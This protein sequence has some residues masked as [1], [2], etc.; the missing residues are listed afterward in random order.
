MVRFLGTLLSPTIEVSPGEA[1]AVRASML[2]CWIKSLLP[3]LEVQKFFR[4]FTLNI[5]QL[6]LKKPAPFI[7]DEC[8]T[9]GE[10]ANQIASDVWSQTFA[11][12]FDART[13]I[14]E[15][16][17]LA[18]DFCIETLLRCGAKWGQG[19]KNR[20]HKPCFQ[21]KK[22]CPGQAS[23]GAST[24][25][26]TSWQQNALRSI[27]EIRIRFS[28]ETCP[29]PD[30]HD[31]QRTISRLRRRLDA[32]RCPHVW[33]PWSQPNLCVL[34][35]CEIW[36]LDSIRQTELKLKQLRIRR[37]REKIK[38]SVASN[39]KYVYRHLKNK[40]K[41][42]P[43]NLVQDAAG[44]VVYDPIHA[45]GVINEKWDDVF[46]ANALHE[47]PTKMLQT[48]WPYICNQSS[49][50]EVPDLTGEHL[51]SVVC[52]RN[53]E[54]SPGLDGWRTTEL[55]SLPTFCFQPFADLFRQ[56]EHDDTEMPEI[57]V[58]AKQLILNKNG[59]S[60][61]MQKR[62]ITVLPIMLLAYTGARF[63]QLQA[64]Q[65]VFMP[66]ELHGGIKTRRMA[67]IPIDLQLQLDEARQS[68]TSMLGLKLDK[69]KCFD[70]IVPN[71][72]AALMLSFGV[73]KHIVRFF[74]KMYA[75]LHRHLAYKS[76]FAPKSTHAA[77]GVAQ[78]CSL[79]LVAIN[80]YMAAWIFMVRNLP[81]LFVRVFIDDSYLWSSL[82]N[83]HALEQAFQ[84]T[85]LWD[86]LSGQKMN[87]SKCTAWGNDRTAR[88]AIRE[89]FSD[90]SH[91]TAFDVLGTLIVT[92]DKQHCR[93]SDSKVNKIILDAR[94][95]A[96]LPL[97][98]P[99]KTKLLGGKVLPQAT[100]GALI[101]MIPKQ[102]TDRITSAIA[103]A[104]WTGRPHW[105][106]KFLVV[107]LLSKA[108]RVDLVLAKAYTTVLDFLRVLHLDATMRC[109]CMALFKCAADTKNNMMRHVIDAFNVFG[110]TID[111]QLSI[112]FHGSAKIPLLELHAKD[113]KRLLAAL[114]ANACYF[115]AQTRARKDFQ[116]P[117]GILDLD[118]TRSSL[119]ELKKI[120]IGAIPA[121]SFLDAV[122]TGCL[123]TN[124]RLC[125]ASLVT[126]PQCR[127]CG[128]E[129]ESTPHLVHECHELHRQI[130][131]PCCHEFGS[132]FAMMGIVEHPLGFVKQRLSWSKPSAISIVPLQR[133]GV[134]LPLWTDG[135]V[136]GGNAFWITAGA[137]AIVDIQGNLVKSGP[138]FHW[139]LSAFTTELWA[140]LEAAALADSF[141]H[142]FMDCK[143]VVDR[144]QVLVNLPEV[145]HD[146]SHG[147]W[148]KFLLHL[149]TH[150]FG[151]NHE[152]FQIS[153][154]PA[155]LC[156]SMPVEMISN[157]LA[158]SCKS[159]VL[160]IDCNRRADFAAKTCCERHAPLHTSRY[161]DL[162]Q[163]ILEHHKWLIEV[164][165][166]LGHEDET[167]I[168]NPLHDDDVE[169]NEDDEQHLRNFFHRWPWVQPPGSLLWTPAPQPAFAKPASWKNTDADWL[170]FCNFLGTLQWD[171]APTLS[172]SYFELACIFH[173]RGFTWENVNPA[174]FQIASLVPKVKK[175]CISIR[176][177]AAHSL[178]PGH[179][180]PDKNRS[181]GKTLPSGTIDGVSLR[182]S[183]YELLRL[184]RFIYY[185]GNHR[186]S[187]WPFVLCDLN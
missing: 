153:W 41:E 24:T 132:N 52:K 22:I 141:V 33:S 167:R 9:T 181:I 142:I 62:L 92:D 87:V 18:N 115:K 64:W 48:I 35:L 134:T 102:V 129:K 138:V 117:A 40:S 81:G 83:K 148:W 63:Q 99:H 65:Q 17:Q 55:Q 139:G 8:T 145:P 169:L 103:H 82:A 53:P 185:G 72:A 121:S 89:L 23:N 37:W 177:S 67:S 168:T 156:E 20:G 96:V 157:E 143:S 79:S 120:T 172:W 71:F 60:D 125:A 56:I 131:A 174:A 69:S 47:E 19:S 162:P 136:L 165:R 164:A 15:K 70:R 32:L 158:Y 78:G 5:D 114:A 3:L 173:L 147:N 150:K 36:L 85:S 176:K 93:L 101:N 160:D 77:N 6:G 42:E 178:L 58:C 111:D 133:F 91:A 39:T 61:A 179:H 159:T 146:W 26:L 31:L 2:F 14:N 186:L 34:Q 151:R 123:L 74:T 88:K 27:H 184:G 107:G 30:Y 76:W 75:K 13:N 105:R 16:L 137:F 28:R 38:E 109:R 155:R 116:K 180:N 171:Q 112:S 183:S 113:I 166:L 170:M 90:M 135:S 152:A 140:V 51:R 126:S 80:V 50:C 49:S 175:A 68:K 122:Q 97:Q 127:F 4:L 29:G 1:M 106:S 163:I 10:A 104:L 128:F 59:S 95:I 118:L 144:F 43:A 108:H 187:S 124:D 149:W 46:A 66:K 119:S 7:L 100:F 25:L 21:T 110:I 73:P 161:H 57:V 98:I 94:N 11:H 182:C 44:N 84:V 154:V 54:A 86:E 130:G 45:L 12:E